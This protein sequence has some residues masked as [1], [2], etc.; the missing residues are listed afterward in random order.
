MRTSRDIRVYRRSVYKKNALYCFRV[1]GL[2]CE[3]L[4]VVLSRETSKSRKVNATHSQTW[5]LNVKATSEGRKGQRHPK[6][7]SDIHQ[8][9]IRF[10]LRRVSVRAVRCLAYSSEEAASRRVGRWVTKLI[11]RA[12]NPSLIEKNT[13]YSC[14]LICRTK[15]ISSPSKFDRIALAIV[16][17]KRWRL[18]R[19]IRRE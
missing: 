3:K 14:A 6:G 7:I 11:S 2:S 4:L 1:H 5:R 18:M 8:R 17:A 15:V 9:K 16:R 19:I 10:T 12:T 13:F